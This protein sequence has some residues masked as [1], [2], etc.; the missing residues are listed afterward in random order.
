[1]LIGEVVKR[2]G[3]A[4]DTIRFYEKMDLME[5]PG[6]CRRQNNYKD[7]P[8]PI[9]QKLLVIQKLKGFGFTLNEIKEMISLYEEDLLVCSDNIPLVKEKIRLIDEK[10]NDLKAVKE[11]LWICI[12]GCPGNCNVEAA[13][14]ELKN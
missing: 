4:R 12:T 7:Y 14:L 3:L 11:H 2:T 13:L 5:I 9:V 6:K 10:I 1:M 8:E